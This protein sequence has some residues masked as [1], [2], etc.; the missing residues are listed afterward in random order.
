M[1]I[2]NLL[3]SNPKLKPTFR[4]GAIVLLTK[5][6]F[7]YS[8]MAGPFNPADPYFKKNCVFMVI[9][10]ACSLFSVN[11]K[12]E[13]ISLLGNSEWCAVEALLDDQDEDEGFD[14]FTGQIRAKDL[15]TI[16]LKD[17]F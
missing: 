14:T 12:N 1:K 10:C 9:E 16:T 6:S 8:D 4:K 17:Y 2:R 11:E 13:N 7:D 15:Q 5:D 3:K